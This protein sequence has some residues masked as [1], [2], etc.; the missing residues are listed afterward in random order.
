MILAEKIVKLR[1]EK[2]WSQEELAMQLNVSRQ[3]VSKWESSASIPDLDR[4][5]KLSQVFEVSTDYLL[6]DEM[7]E[8]KAQIVTIEDTFTEEAL[9]TRAISIEEVN[10][11]MNLVERSAKKMAAAVSACILSPVLLILLAGLSEYG[12]LSI[13]EDM[14]GGIGVT[15]LLLIIAGAVATFIMLGMKLDKYDFLEFENISLQ[16]GGYGAVE[17]KREEF[18]P[19]FKKCI[20]IGVVLCIVSVVPLMVAAALSLKEIAYIY[21]VVL[22][23]FFVAF[24]V[25]LMVWSGM[26][27]GSYQKLMEEGEYTRENKLEN[28]QN[29]NL[30]KVYWCTVT[31]IY[32]GVSFWTQRWD[33]SWI[34]W[35][36]AGVLFAAVC[37]VAAMLR[38]K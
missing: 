1:K 26:I 27:Y 3:S 36:V 10:K 2:G 9:P 5:L 7:E 34:I 4:I 23:L 35:P 18:E 20:T 17:K 30:S 31:A 28:R 29:K 6:K 37:G 32:L 38:K 15:I 33:R 14:A 12:I 19:T 11:Y 25:F 21:C 24:G 8:N 13:T 22:L 16:Y